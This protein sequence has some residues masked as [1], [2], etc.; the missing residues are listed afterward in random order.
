VETQQDARR[1]LPIVRAQ[2]AGIGIALQRRVLV[3]LVEPAGLLPSPSMDGVLFAVTEHRIRGEDRETVEIRVAAGMP[4]QHFGRT[5][6]HE[7]GHAWL[8]QEHAPPLAAELEEGLCELFAHAW[9]K[10]QHTP[11]TDE[12]QRRL[13]DNPDPVYGAG[14]RLVLTAVRT[15]GIRPV[16]T[17]LTRD[18]VLP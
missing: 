16:L 8:V 13:W 12:M 15:F 1:L 18:G 9:L 6:A 5:V 7:I 14:L 10:Q 17:S 2:L 4:P 11:L 3:R